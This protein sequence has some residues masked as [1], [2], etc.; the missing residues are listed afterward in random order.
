VRVQGLMVNAQSVLGHT[1]QSERN[2]F[3]LFT[4][5]RDRYQCAPLQPDT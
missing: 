1:P 2:L 5:M 4:D 3:K